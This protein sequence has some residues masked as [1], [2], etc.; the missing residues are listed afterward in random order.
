MAEQTDCRTAMS[1]PPPRRAR[2]KKSHIWQIAV[3]VLAVTACA[4]QLFYQPRFG[5]STALQLQIPAI[6]I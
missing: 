2:W 5:S 6:D 4:I 1:E 3:G